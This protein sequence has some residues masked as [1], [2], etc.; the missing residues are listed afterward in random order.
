MTLFNPFKTNLNT[1]RDPAQFAL[2]VT[3]SDSIP[4]TSVARAVW[5]GTAGNLQVMTAGGVVVNIPNASGLIPI[6][7]LQVYATGTTATGI[8]IFY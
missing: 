7:L 2:A 8:V 1:L 5:V 6:G 4:L 3:P